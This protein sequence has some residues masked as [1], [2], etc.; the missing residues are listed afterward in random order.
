MSSWRKPE[1]YKLVREYGAYPGDIAYSMLP[2]YEGLT[3]EFVGREVTA[4]RHLWFVEDA[5][6]EWRRQKFKSPGNKGSQIQVPF[7]VIVT[8]TLS[9]PHPVA[10]IKMP[11]V[12]DFNSGKHGL[13]TLTAYVAKKKTYKGPD[14]K[15]KIFTVE[16]F[17]HCSRIAEQA[18][19]GTLFGKNG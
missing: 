16:N 5:V 10:G 17:T 18:C 4:P 9:L 15:Q 8:G 14:I 7:R 2:K 11:N 12:R 19:Q 6:A 1:L 13:D 3:I